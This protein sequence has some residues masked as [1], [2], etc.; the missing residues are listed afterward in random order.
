MIRYNWACC[1]RLLCCRF[2]AA[3]VSDSPWTSPCCTTVPAYF[4]SGFATV[5]P[6]TLRFPKPLIRCWRLGNLLRHIRTLRQRINYV[7]GYDDCV[8]FGPDIS[9]VV[10]KRRLQRVEH[11]RKF[12]HFQEQAFVPVSAAVPEASSRIVQEDFLF[13]PTNQVKRCQ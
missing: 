12:S 9:S 2:C 1:A 10:S 3:L 7:P 13:Q 6:G 4:L 5:K 11:L 8:L